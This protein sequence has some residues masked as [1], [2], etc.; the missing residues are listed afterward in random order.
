MVCVEG[1]VVGRGLER[2]RSLDRVALV[3]LFLLSFF[4][5][6][7]LFGLEVVSV[8]VCWMVSLLACFFA[9]VVAV[10]AV[11]VAVVVMAMVTTKGK[12][13]AGAGEGLELVT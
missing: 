2:R 10:V 1:V 4:A 12:D 8:G 5:R 6:S 11:V 3:L 13:G 7:F 9:L